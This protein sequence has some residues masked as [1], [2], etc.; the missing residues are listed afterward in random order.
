MSRRWGLI[1]CGTLAALPAL[2]ALL[3]GRVPGTVELN[4]GP[5]DAPYVSGFTPEYEIDDRVATHWTSYVAQVELPLRVEGAL[6]VAYRFARV[7]P[8][9]AQVEVLLD[10]RTIDRFESRG[11]IFAV[12]RVDVGHVPSAALSLA[13]RVDSHDRRNLGLKLDWVRFESGPGGR[14]RLQGRAR[15]QAALVVALLV[16]LLRWAGWGAGHAALLALPVS[17]A[18]S[19]GLLASP[20]LLHRLLAGVPVSLALLGAALVGGGRALVARG[21][22]AVESL[23]LACAL[24]ILAFLLRAAAVNHPGFYHPDLRSHARFAQ[25][26]REMGPR[27]LASPREL[28]LEHGVWKTERRGRQVVFPYSP[29][30]HAPFALSPLGYDDMLL[31]MKLGGAMLSIVPLVVVFAL[32]RDLEASRLGAVLMVLV[33]TYTSRLSFAFLPALFGHA[34]DTAFILW[35]SRRLE[36]V[37]SRPVWLAGTAF[38][39]LCQLAYISGVLNTGVLLVSLAAML[40]MPIGLRIDPMRALA[41]LGMGALGSL[42]SLLAFYRHFLSAVPGLLQ[43]PSPG[44]VPVYPTQSFWA[45]A[46]ARTHDFFDGVLPALAVVGLIAL[47]RRGRSRALLLGWTLAYL[48]LLLG[49]AKLP[50]VFLHGHETLLF[51][52]LLC[53]AAGEAL[54]LLG[55]RGGWGR[56]AAIALLA[57]VAAQ[58]LAAQWR[59]VARQLA[60]AL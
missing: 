13:F 12:R 20:W 48:L 36:R 26:L 27:G 16:F 9:T 17:A 43:A 53:L 39:A 58:G 18:A 47:V 6:A 41:V 7:L 22:S 45:V 29:A 2:A 49:R 8:E 4:L 60:N 54:S 38:V 57:L 25:G 40:V 15:W 55:R 30:F 44:A 14:A 50:E 24:G 28:V 59:A 19:L 31:A 51:T 56:A 11:G 46:L 52:P 34:I 35:L 5:G 21:W 1:A 33:P 23:R 3:G 32:A 42:L 10:G 37:L